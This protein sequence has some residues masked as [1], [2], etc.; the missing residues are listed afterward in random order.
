MGVPDPR[1]VNQANDLFDALLVLGVAEIQAYDDGRLRIGGGG[2][3]VQL[4]P[5]LHYSASLSVPRLTGREGTT[6][7]MACL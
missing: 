1:A 2:G 7:E 3:T 5:S 6:V 4:E